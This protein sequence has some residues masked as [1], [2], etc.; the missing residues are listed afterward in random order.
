MEKSDKKKIVF[1]E[2]KSP[3]LHI[4]SV[5]VIPRLGTLILGTIMKK[6]GWEVEVFIEENHDIDFETLR[7]ADMVGISTITST[8]TR[9]YYIADRVREMNIPVIMG[10]PHV[11]YLPEEALGHCDYVIRSEGEKAFPKFIKCWSDGKGFSGVPNLSYRSTDGTII[12]NNVL[13]F[14]TDLDSIPYPDLSLIKNGLKKTFGYSVIPVQ[15]SRGCPFDCEFC[16]VTGMFGH[17]IRYRSTENILEELKQYNDKK[18]VIFFYDDNFT[19]NK[20]RTRALLKAMIKENFEF[21]WS[22]QVRADIAKDPE[23]IKLMKKAGCETV[24]IGFESVD[25]ESL[26]EMN[27]NQSVEE[28]KNSIRIF[29]KNKIHIHGM[30]VFGFES[31]TLKKINETI[32]FVNKSGIGTAQFL[33]LTPF[34][35]TATFEKL[36]NEKRIKFFDWALYDAHH[37]VFEPNNF[38]IEDLQQAQIKGHQSFYSLK[39]LLKHTLRFKVNALVIGFYARKLNRTWK[40]RNKIWLKALD[41]VKPN[42]DFKINIDFRQ[43]VQF[44]KPEDINSRQ[45]TGMAATRMR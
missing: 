28:I 38:T 42:F 34:P 25:P 29:H 4:F 15:T 40:K 20:K 11:T 2:P 13:D 14:M 7:S 3:N 1:I 21:K 45:K 23:M 26:L 33:I 6:M 17:K 36:K 12:H 44:P 35:G 27:K 31:D 10:G 37:A 32:K 24:F 16:S 8:A 5:F 19:A 22:T 41:L 30:F 43:M 39:Q 18:N 9:A